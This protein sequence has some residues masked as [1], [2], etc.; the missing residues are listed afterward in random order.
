MTNFFST[1]VSTKRDFALNPLF[2]MLT[3]HRYPTA[4]SDNCEVNL[5]IS[6]YTTLSTQFSFANFD[7][8][9]GVVTIH[10]VIY[11]PQV[12]YRYH[13][14]LKVM[15]RFK[16]AYDG[17]F[18]QNETCVEGSIRGFCINFWHFCCHFC[19]NI[20]L[21]FLNYGYKGPLGVG[22]LRDNGIGKNFKPPVE[23]AAA[24]IKLVCS[25]SLLLSLL[26]FLNYGYRGPWGVGP[27]RDN[28]MSQNP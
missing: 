16:S 9:T 2:T 6:Q 10:F 19:W 4:T 18:L 21:R 24:S 11:I 15:K 28:G 17:K 5:A 8:S 3:R 20:V 13:V 22:A 23:D 12:Y 14:C 25:L 26:C 27:L 1:T 7:P